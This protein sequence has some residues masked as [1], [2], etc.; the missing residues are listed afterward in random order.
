MV[1]MKNYKWLMLA[2]ILIFAY[3][4]AG[5]SVA[6][7]DLLTGLEPVTEFNEHHENQGNS[8]V[9][10]AF[11]DTVYDSV[12]WRAMDLD[13]SFS[14]V[15]ATMVTLQGNTIIVEGEGAEV[16][17]S[18]LLITA[19]GTY[20]ITGDL[21]NGQII[22]NAPGDDPVRIILNGVDLTSNEGSPFYVQN[23]GIA[24]ITLAEG[25]AN[26]FT[27]GEEYFFPGPNN[28]PDAAFY[29]NCDLTINGS[30]ALV[31]YGKYKD[32]L[33][34]KKELKIINGVV[35]VNATEVG[36]R[37][38]DLIAIREAHVA[39][40]AGTDGIQALGKGDSQSG[41]VVIKGGIIDI[42][43]VMKGIEATANLVIVDGE[44]LIESGYGIKQNDA[45][46]L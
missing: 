21:N 24:V 30:G 34:S 14:M 9:R 12:Q 15:D 35:K 37:G 38:N 41:L 44:I 2:L 18:K 4:L 23:A 29:S 5:C 13:E 40:K 1:I 26:T 20:I 32:G 3:P 31:I 43:A 22:I 27:D 36:I 19:A 8:P 39:I 33:V 16:D 25:T 10:R 46:E 42:Y 7:V 45:N 6:S 11:F 17:G 28:E